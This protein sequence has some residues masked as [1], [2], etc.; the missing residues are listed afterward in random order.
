MEK[1]AARYIWVGEERRKFVS[2]KDGG[3]LSKR[4]KSG[5]E[6]RKKKKSEHGVM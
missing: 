1:V 4:D 5:E 2:R 6:A 3:K